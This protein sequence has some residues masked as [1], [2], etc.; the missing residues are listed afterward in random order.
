MNIIGIDISKATFDVHLIKEDQ[1]YSGEFSN[2]KKGFRTF[3]NWLKKRDV[4]TGWACMEATGR[5]GDELADY[6]YEASYQVSVVNPARTSKYLDSKLTRTTNDRIAAELI[7]DF[8]LT[9][10]PELWKP[11]PPEVKTLQQLVRRVHSLKET[12]AQELNRGQGAAI[13][14]LVAKSINKVIKALDKEID[15]LQQQVKTHV[16]QYPDLKKQKDLLVSIPGIADVSALEIM[17][18]IGNLSRFE[19]A[20][21]LVAYAGLSPKSRDSGT[22]V[23]SKPRLSKI[24]NSRLRTALFFPALSALQHNPI[25]IALKQRLEARHK[26]KMVIVGAAM[27]KLLRLAYGVLKTGKTFDPNFVMNMQNTA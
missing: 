8:C 7:A 26:V 21:Q 13:D 12:R 9:Q 19:C 14:P 23:K 27:R 20:D 5:Y 18:E 10:K 17:S 16:D 4:A 15:A 24:G 11:S 2:D 22:S 25:I 1:T 6:L 3:R